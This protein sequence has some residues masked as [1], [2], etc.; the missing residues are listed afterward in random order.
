ML[1]PFDLP[2]LSLWKSEPD[3]TKRRREILLDRVV[4]LYWHLLYYVQPLCQIDGWTLL[5]RRFIL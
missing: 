5:A 1:V 2:L 4:H 3:E